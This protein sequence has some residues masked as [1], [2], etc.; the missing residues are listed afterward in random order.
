MASRKTH[1]LV[2]RIF[3]GQ[4]YE[5]VNS[6]MDNP[7]KYFGPIHRKYLHS[8]LDAVMVGIMFRDPK[9]TIAALIHQQTDFVSTYLK[10]KIR[11]KI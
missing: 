4:D 2:N 10:K 1:N 8:P 7:A 5:H 6:L 9:A 11:K 3:L